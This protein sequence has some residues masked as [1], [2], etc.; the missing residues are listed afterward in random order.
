MADVD[1]VAHYCSDEFAPFPFQYSE[2]YLNINHDLTIYLRQRIAFV[3]V[4]DFDALILINLFSLKI[5]KETASEY[6]PRDARA[7]FKS[8]SDTIYEQAL[9]TYFD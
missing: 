1:P 3:R 8:F 9:R 7:L 6:L 5:S 4:G 2:K